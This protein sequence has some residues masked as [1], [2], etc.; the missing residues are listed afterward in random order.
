MSW[1]PAIYLLVGLAYAPYALLVLIRRIDEDVQGASIG[2][3]VLLVPSVV[4]L[5]P[6]LVRKQLELRRT[7]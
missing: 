4:L 3:Y 7:G 2:F 6:V 5:W 1:I